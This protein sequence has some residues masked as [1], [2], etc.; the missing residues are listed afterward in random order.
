MADARTDTA[1]IVERIRPV[2]AGGAVVAVYFLGDTP[3]FVLGE[4][5][6]L[7]CHEGEERRLAVHGGA[8][9]GSAGDGNRILTGGDD[10]KV[11]AIDG[12]GEPETIAPTTAKK[13]PT[14][15]CP[16]RPML[17]MPALV[18]NDPPSPTRRIGAVVRN[19][20]TIRKMLKRRPRTSTVA[21]P[22]CCPT[23]R[24]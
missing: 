8:I 14:S 23:R 7:F 11:V 22:P 21:L 2:A 3:V 10:G 13:A 18:V 19:V 12:K 5:A 1:S 6:L 9:L 20:A 16:S 4:E 17:K 24:A 15:I